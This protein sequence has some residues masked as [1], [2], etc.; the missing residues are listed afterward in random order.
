MD[1]I[2]RNQPEHNRE[3]LA[4]GS[5]IARIRE[6]TKDAESCFFCTTPLTG[7]ATGGTRPM[8]IEEADDAGA[9][10]F[11][12]ASD[13]HKNAEIEADPTVRLYFQASKHSGFLAL[14]GRATIS[15]DRQRIDDLWNPIMKTWFT[16]G[17]D[18]P[19]ITVIQVTPTGGYYWDNKHGDFV[20]ASK[21]VVG[22][23]L[24][25]T[26]DDSIEGRVSP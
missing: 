11:L 25:K 1:S 9:L 12:S 22:A 21:M 16:G 26:L 6:M 15:R 10:W 14:D 5:A 19:R 7:S 3:D 23:A 17:K 18:D 2:N 13:S 4:G 24:G 8:A 20:A